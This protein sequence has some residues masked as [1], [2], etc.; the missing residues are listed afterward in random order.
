MIDQ[1]GIDRPVMHACGHDMH[2]T[3]LPA[4]SE[5]MHSS[6]SHW[7]GTLIVLFQPNEEHTGG[8]QAMLDDGLYDKVKVPDIVLGQHSMPMRTGRVNVRSGTDTFSS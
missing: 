8:A 7:S 3:C 1:Y 5:L 4:A 6:R 2:L